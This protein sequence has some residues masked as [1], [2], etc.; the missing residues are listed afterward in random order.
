MWKKKEKA[1]HSLVIFLAVY[2]PAAIYKII[3]IIW[4]ERLT[5]N[6]SSNSVCSPLMLIGW[7]NIRSKA[8]MTIEDVISQ[9]HLSFLL[10]LFE[11]AEFR[12]SF[13]A[14][15]IEHWIYMV[16]TDEKIKI[17]QCTCTDFFTKWGSRI[18]LMWLII[19]S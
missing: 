11:F 19:K 15:L 9:S 5:Y 4:K 7:F 3:D 13:P 2:L 17:K 10:S 12:L 6:R 8:N 1:Y 18:P 16:T 14:I